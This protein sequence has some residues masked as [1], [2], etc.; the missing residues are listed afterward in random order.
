MITEE[1]LNVARAG[2]KVLWGIDNQRQA[3]NWLDLSNLGSEWTVR[4]T[5]LKLIH[6]SGGFVQF[7]AKTRAHYV[8][9]GIAWDLTN[10]EGLLLVRSER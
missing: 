9:I 10:M 4:A 8:G 6:E 5:F 2:G 1:A 7:T 3:Q